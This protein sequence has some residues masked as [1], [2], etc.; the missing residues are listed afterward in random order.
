MDGISL[1]E[2]C[3]ALYPGIFFVVLTF[4]EDFHHVQSALR[5]GAID[6][7]SKFQMETIDCDQLLKRISEKVEDIMARQIARAEANKKDGIRHDSGCVGTA[8]AFEEKEWQT[9]VKRWT[10]MH[11]LYDDSTFEELSISTRQID[12]SVRKVEQV[13]LPLIHHAQESIGII[14]KN[15]PEFQNL[16]NLF[17]WLTEFR[18][19]LYHIMIPE[20][21]TDKTAKI[22]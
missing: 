6:Y 8:R 20:I 13:L 9:L 22:S 2:K 17:R 16:D 4:Y 3:H 10:E 5:I 11:W 7:I 18:E 14:I 12:I 19:A 15:I 21:K 1:M